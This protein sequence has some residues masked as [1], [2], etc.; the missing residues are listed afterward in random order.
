MT[1]ELRI[2]TVNLKSLDQDID[3]PIV[4][5]A[6]D[7][8]GMTFRVIFTQEAEA[9]M[10][11]DSKVYLK[12]WN[13]ATNTKGYNV[14]TKVSD[15]PCI[16]KIHWPQAMLS[17]G[18]VLCRIELVDSVSISPSTNFN[19][20]VLSDPDDGSKYILSD[21][22]SEFQKA[23]IQMTTL[24]DRIRDEFNIWSSQI[25]QI[26]SDAA[27]AKEDANAAKIISQNTRDEWEVYKKEGMPIYMQEY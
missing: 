11:P 24:T 25:D 13:Q 8:N 2:L 18:T 7:A 10:T 26:K 12:W 16:W 17:E 3:D 15:D 22:Y 19:V 9:Q 1:Q 4:A 14:F 5:G 23:V 6:G 21:D 20:H 27:Q